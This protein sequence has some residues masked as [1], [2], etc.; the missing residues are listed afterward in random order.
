M[1]NKNNE[2][3]STYSDYFNVVQPK[4]EPSPSTLTPPLEL[5]P[6]IYIVIGL[7]IFLVLLIIGLCTIL[8]FYKRRNKHL[9]EEVISES[10]SGSLG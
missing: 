7:F 6:I 5:P 3:M 9:E 1:I 8:C 10:L 2:P 4:A